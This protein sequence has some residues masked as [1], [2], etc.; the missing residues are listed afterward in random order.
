MA[1]LE[2]AARAAAAEAR[3]SRGSD[4]TVRRG[5]GG[6]TRGCVCRRSWKDTDRS[7]RLPLLSRKVGERAR[8]IEE[9]ER[10]RFAFGG[11]L[12]A[13]SVSTV[14]VNPGV[15]DGDGRA[16]Q[17]GRRVEYERSFDRR[18]RP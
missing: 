15:G 3:P 7:V 5:V 4:E 11:A 14:M 18:A 2:A 9:K 10:V 17:K 12:T 16:I 8:A 6:C 1:G 13:F